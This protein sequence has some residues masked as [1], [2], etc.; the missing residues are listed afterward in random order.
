MSTWPAPL[1][2][3]CPSAGLVA[4]DEQQHAAYH[5]LIGG[6]ATCARLCWCGRCD[7]YAAQ[8]A[9]VELLR[10]QEYAARDR[11][12]GERSARRS[13]TAA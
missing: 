3:G 11:R 7:Q 5:E 1:P 4:I 13:R 9:A 10:Q 6:P 12:E 2:C 8:R